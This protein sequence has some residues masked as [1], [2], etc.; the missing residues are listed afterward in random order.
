MMSRHS[1]G[2]G[3]Q[4][5]SA[6]GFLQ[7]LTAGA[8][9]ETRIARAYIDTSR[10]KGLHMSVLAIGIVVAI[11]LSGLVA[12]YLMRRQAIAVRAHRDSVPEDFAGEVGLED[13]RRAAD[14]TLARTRLASVET[15]FDT[16]IGVLWLLVLLAPLYAVLA[17]IIPQGLTRSVAVVLCVAAVGHVLG[18]PFSIYKTF[19]LEA[20]FGFNRMTPALFLRDELKGA[21]LRLALGVPLLYGLFFLLRALPELWWILGFAAVM[22]LMLVMLVVYPTLIAPLFN[23]FTPMQDESMRARIEALLRQ[24]GFEA[25]GLFVMDASKRSTHGNAYFAG[26]GKAKRI[27]FFDTLLAKHSPDEILSILAH[28][29]GHYKLGHIGQRI[30]ETAVFSFVGFLVLGWAFASDALSRAFGLPNDPGLVLVIV[31]IA[32]G[33]VMHLLAPVTS[34]LSRRAE[35]QA[36][37]FAKALLGPESMIRALTKLSRDNL[38]TLTPDEL[39]VLFY[40]SHPPVPVRIDRLKGA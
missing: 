14:Y 4:D 16:F 23:K 17:E 19:W 2:N 6:P 11:C 36:D 5:P 25:K 26:F 9:L 39:Y 10:M 7:S 31:L 13:H 28:E 35:F 29:L 33:P 40:Y 37:A 18:L 21:A 34:F 20:S 27:V 38:S 24:C 22:A 1:G 15:I 30:A 12:L 8:Q 32:G 3:T